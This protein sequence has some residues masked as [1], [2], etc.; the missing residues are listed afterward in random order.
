MAIPERAALRLAEMIRDQLRLLQASRHREVI[1]RM[2]ELTQKLT[3]L[4]RLGELLSFSL[5]RD[6]R[7]AA[8][9]VVERL[10]CAI[11]DLPYH[12]GQVERTVET[13]KGKLPSVRD[14]LADIEQL[15]EEFEEYKYDK[16]K[17]L[18]VVTTEPIELEGV[19]L[20][21][22]EIQLRAGELA[23]MMRHSSTY[24]IVAL[25][26]HPAASNDAV[27]HPHV[28]DEHLC[29][30]DASAAIDA[31]LAGG[32]ICD[33]FHL[34][35]AVLTTYN[36]DSPYVPLD[37]WEGVACHDCGYTTDADNVCCC[38]VCGND[39]CDE[40]ASYCQ[41]CNSTVCIGCLEKCRVCDEPVCPGCMTECG[42]C[43][44]SLCRS[45]L[46]DGAC[47]CHDEEEEEDQ[48]EQEQE[49]KEDQQDR[50][51][52]PKETEDERQSQQ[53]PSAVRDGGGETDRDSARG[54][55]RQ[56]GAAAA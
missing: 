29:E 49:Q 6:W 13:G 15:A 24:R 43:G 21:A 7:A 53:T 11:R 37:R 16:D 51:E 38:E 35:R 10:L 17:Q 3:H 44:E 28:S 5:D 12:A 9:D 2:R 46:D 54:P 30:G 40:C 42:S 31:A 34:V 33:F 25:D 8:A 1:R 47:P 45:C 56:A 26:P 50:R 20:G 18:L 27:T 36:P 41:R 23:G 4:N 32:R 48:E 52:G 14:I 55:A 22:F 39:F 19:Y